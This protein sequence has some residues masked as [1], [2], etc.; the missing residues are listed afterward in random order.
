[1]NTGSRVTLVTGA[2][3]FAG[4][5]LVELL[6]GRGELVG[7]SRSDPSVPLS[8]LATWQRIDL[9]DRDRVRAA[10]ADLKPSAIYHC[11]GAAH[12]AHSWNNATDSLSSNVLATHYLLDAV[13]RANIPCRVLIPGSAM[14]YAPSGTPITEDHPVAPDSPYALSKLAQEQLGLRA[15]SEDGVTVIVTRS[16]NHTGP[17]QSPDFAAPAMA[18]QIALIESG[19][20]EPL[21]K[22][23]NL[24]AHRDLTDVRDTVR[25]YA[26]L[27]EHGV[28]GV[29]YNIA[30]GI[31]RPIRTLLEAL[32][33]RSRAVVRIQTDEA[34]LRP[35]DRPFLIGDASRLRL[36]TGW[37]PTIDFDRMLDDLLKYW[38]ETVQQG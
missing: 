36:L 23:G 2:A 15:V 30:T 19:R 12:V 26:L 38:R 10:I 11:A 6:S 28:G 1:M 5:H 24:E 7:W 25:A 9:L 34:L 4:S 37:V 21:I 29:V 17:R 13:R 18:R 31:G 3:G 27:M 33:A 32:V 35:L 14:V 20:L 22:V 8:G 16:F